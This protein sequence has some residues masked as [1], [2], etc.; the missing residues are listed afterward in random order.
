LGAKMPDLGTSNFTIAFWVKT[1]SEGGAFFIKSPE[2]REGGGFEAKVLYLENGAPIYTVL[3]S[4][5]LDSE[6]KINDGEWHHIALTGNSPHEFFI[7]GRQVQKGTKGTFDE[8]SSEGSEYTIIVGNNLRDEEDEDSERFQGLI[9]EMRIYNYRLSGQEIETIISEPSQVVDG[10]A[11]HW[12]F[13]DNRR[14]EDA[15]G[16]GYRA[17]LYRAEQAEGKIGNA[18]QFNGGGLMWFSPRRMRR[19]DPRSELWDIVSGEFSSEEAVREIKWERADGIWDSDWETGDLADLADRYAAVTREIGDLPSQAKSLAEKLKTAEELETLRNIYYLSL[20]NQIAYDDLNSKIGNVR[21]AVSYLTEE[22]KKDYPKGSEYLKELEV[23][24]KR[25]APLKEKPVETEVIDELNESFKKL[26]YKALVTNNPVFDFDKLLFVKRYTYQSS[27]YYTD[28]IDGCRNFGGNISI[29]SLK[30]GTVTDVIPELNKG[31]FGRYDLHFNTDRVLFDW[32]EKQEV[33]F[34]IFEV[35]LDGKGLRQLTFPPE[36][37]EERIKRYDNRFTGAWGGW[38]NHHTDDMHP[39]YLPDGRIVFTSSR[40]EYGTLCDGPDV[41]ATALL[42][43]IDADGS[44]MVKLTNSSVSEFS[45]SIMH[46]GRILYSRWEY[47]DK[48]QIGVKCLWAMRPDGSGSVE[49]YGNDIALPP[50]FVHSRQIP[51]YNNLFVVLGTPHFPQSGVG[52]VIRLDINKPIRTRE[53]MTYITPHIDIRAEGGFH[54]R[55]GDKWERNLY[56]PLYMD[57]YPL[58]DKFFLVSHNPDKIWNDISAWG[59]YIIDEFGNHVQIYQDPEFSSWQPMPLKAR[60]TPPVI[61]PMIAEKEAEQKEAVVVLS[62][63]YEGLDGI[64]KGSIKY[65]RIME[66]VPRPW[67]C[68]H[69]WDQ[70]GRYCGHTGLISNGPV[71][72]LK[73]LH[74]IVPVYEDGSAHFVVPTDKNIYFQALDENYMEVQRQRTYINYRPGEQRACIGCH[75]YRQQAPANKHVTALNHPPSSPGPQPGEQ[76]PRV[77]HFPTDVQPVLDKHCVS[78]HGGPS[79]AGD[80]DLTGEMTEIFTRSYDSIMQRGL[81]E[82]TDEGS[83]FGGT[84]PVAPKTI[85]SHGSRFIT[86]ILSG[87]EGVK[88]SREEMIKLTTWVDSNAQ[89]YGT[90]YGRKNIVYKDHPDFRPLP[91]FAEAVSTKSPLI[92]SGPETTEIQTD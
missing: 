27:H 83:D 57:P 17:R 49:I 3:E 68:R 84:E 6:T 43:R 75:E 21:N 34:R 82:T 19:R 79:P 37:E 2:E 7:D 10:L 33:G 88:L 44:N 22:F 60:K 89:Y 18:A 45:P 87:H 64:E 65:I 71:L 5:N 51:N 9:D 67:D 92:A 15:S 70:E 35:G 61:P 39:I 59:L 80:M 20:R 78:C 29:L 11:V 40:C 42:Y 91:T 12:A 86:T 52:T 69:F 62:D 30:D 77:V 28:F 41:L 13:E 56:G 74:G 8:M 23:L 55:V 32:K 26:Q 90:Y 53:P 38:Y 1:E 31:I 58:N 14:I 63:V 72:G 36:D 54:H 48:G 81:V 4:G 50:V 24:D 16:N 46:D 76:A 66:Q 85:G 25:V 73:V 47:V